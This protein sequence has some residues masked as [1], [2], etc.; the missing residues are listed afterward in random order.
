MKNLAVLRKEQ[1]LSQQK[2]ASD[3][4]LARNTICQYESGNRV[5]DVS[6]LVLLA[7]YFGVSTDYLLGRDYVISSYQIFVE[8]C[9]KEGKSIFEVA[10]EFGITDEQLTQWKNGVEPS[11]RTLWAISNAYHYYSG[12]PFDKAKEKKSVTERPTST[13]STASVPALFGD[14][15]D[16][17]S[18]ARFVNTAKIYHE[19]PDEMRERAYGLI[20]GIAIG[21]GLNVNDIIGR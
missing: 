17:L 14:M 10:K 21:L 16:L 6:T 18:E 5:P 12:N 9:A 15:P 1:G 7:D 3:I 13:S 11:E 4:G 19:L 8:I 20:C 2:L